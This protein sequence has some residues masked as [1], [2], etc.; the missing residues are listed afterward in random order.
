M[1]ILTNN[2]RIAVNAHYYSLGDSYFHC[3]ETLVALYCVKCD[4]M[5]PCYYC[6]HDYSEAHD[7]EAHDD[8]ECLTFP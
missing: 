7:C 6:E 2:R 1:S 8:C 4:D 3:G 5:M